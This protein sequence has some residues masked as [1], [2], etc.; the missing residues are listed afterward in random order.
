MR[1]DNGRETVSPR[2]RELSRVDALR[3]EAQMLVSFPHA[4]APLPK[5]CERPIDGAR[6]SAPGRVPRAAYSPIRGGLE[7][8]YG[9]TMSM[10]V[11]LPQFQLYTYSIRHYR[12]R[13]GARD[14]DGRFIEEGSLWERRKE[15]AIAICDVRGEVRGPGQ[16]RAG[17]RTKMKLNY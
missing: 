6:S 2:V 10:T 14:H 12:T 9:D 4:L 13:H 16:G 17:L 8:I 7:E 5:P 11:S 15:Y 3:S 1:S